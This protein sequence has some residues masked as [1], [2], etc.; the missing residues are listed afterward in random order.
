MLFHPIHHR[1]VVCRPFHTSSPRHVHPLIWVFL[2]PTLK[3]V[4]W[5][6]GRTTRKWFRDLPPEKRSILTQHLNRN[7]LRYLGIFG[8]ISAIAGFH[9]YTHLQTAPITNRRRYMIMN[10]EQL[11][12]LSDMEKENIA[13]EFQNKML[14]EGSKATQVVAKVAKR[15]LTANMDI[16]QIKAIKWSVRV[17]DTDMKNA[18]VLPTGDIYATRGLLETMTNQDQLAIVLAHELSHAILDH[19]AEKISFLQVIDVAALLGAF[20]IWAILPSD[21]TSFIVN[22]IFEG[23]ITLTSRL[24]YSRQ[25]EQEADEVGLML[26]AKA[27]IDVREAV[28]F[29]RLAQEQENKE[30]LPEFV[31]THPA[32]E[33]RAEN[34]EEKLPWALEIRQLCKCYPLPEKKILG[35]LNITKH[36]EEKIMGSVDKKIPTIHHIPIVQTT[37]K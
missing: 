14:P 2:K 29:W 25:L 20:V 7:K 9:Y 8:T 36:P 27:C 13:K 34:L 23:F 15:I 37:K 32:H 28:N 10:M 17:V 19:S 3:G 31:S 18:F 4:A 1:S 21:L 11:K 5:L 33:H 26:A 22:Y 35:A 16:P 12:V 24:P 6:T 30:A